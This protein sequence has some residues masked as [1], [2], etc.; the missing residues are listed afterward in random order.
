MFFTIAIVLLQE[1]IDKGIH[2]ILPEILVLG[3]L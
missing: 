2:D 1:P 3:S